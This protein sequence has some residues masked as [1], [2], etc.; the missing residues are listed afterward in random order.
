MAEEVA[1]IER[2]AHPF[3]EVPLFAFLAVVLEATCCSVASWYPFGQS[4]SKSSG[5]A[6][7]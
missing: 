6:A 7:A 5:T 4:S 2:A 3:G 1:F